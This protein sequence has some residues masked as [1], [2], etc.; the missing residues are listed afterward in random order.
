MNKSHLIAHV[1]SA[2]GGHKFKIST[3]HLIAPVRSGEG[4]RQFA[5]GWPLGMRRPSAHGRGGPTDAGR[6]VVGAPGTLGSPRR[7]S[8]KG[9]PDRL[10]VGDFLGGT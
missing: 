7:P 2:E 5:L 3:S 8:S 6:R 1:R 10:P 9:E 4:G